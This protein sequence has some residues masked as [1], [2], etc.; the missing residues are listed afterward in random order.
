MNNS[1]TPAGQERRVKSVNF[2]DQA[3][4][5]Y[6]S[7][8][9]D[10]LYGGNFSGYVT[11]LIERDRSMG[12][13]RRTLHD[14]EAQILKIIEPYGGRLADGH[15]PYDFEVPSLKLVIEA[16]SR[17]PRERQ[18]E[19]QLLSAMQKIAF[20]QPLTRIIVTYPPDISDAEKERFRQFETAGIENLRA[21]D[22]NDL[23]KFLAALVQ[24]G[25][26]K[27]EE[28]LLDQ[29]ETDVVQPSRGLPPTF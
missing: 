1:P 5:D 18:L 11:A 13:S 19:Y 7:Q 4:F 16:R 22:L 20:A 24:P 21:C 3:L 28:V 23:A 26:Y 14:L 10:N 25:A 17:F 8:R 9:A 2:T 29:E 6:A 27:L 15:D 12:E